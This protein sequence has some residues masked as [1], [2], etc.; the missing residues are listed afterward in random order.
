MTINGSLSGTFLEIQAKFP[1]GAAVT[2]DY[3][4]PG[5]QFSLSIGYGET[6]GQLRHWEADAGAAGASGSATL[7]ADGSGVMRA[8]VPVALVM[9]GDATGPI[10]VSGQWVCP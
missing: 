6:F 5:S 4:A 10:T 8:T 7:T 1:A 9:P 3:G 2:L